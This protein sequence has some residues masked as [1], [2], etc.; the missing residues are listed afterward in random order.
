[1][2]R[3]E[4]RVSANIWEDRD[5]CAL[6]FGAQWI[7]EF[8]LSQRDLAH[9]GVIALRERRWSQHARGM[10][11]EVMTASLAEL[12]H[13]RYVVVDRDS[14]ELLVRT[15]I[16]NDKI[17]RQPNV[18]RA[19][20]DHL[21]LVLSAII[22]AA[23]AEE[24]AKVAQLDMGQ[25]SRAILDE[26]R[27][28]LETPGRN[29]QGDPAANP[30]GNPSQDPSAG[31]PG[32][33]GVVTAVTT[34]FPVPRT[35]NPVTPAGSTRAR[36]ARPP[37]TDAAFDQFWATYPL[38]VGKRT[39]RKA[40]DKAISHTDPELIL[41]GAQRYRDLPGREPKYTAHPATWLNADRWTDEPA[42]GQAGAS[43]N[44]QPKPSTTDA[45]VAAALAAGAEVQA[46]IDR[47]EI[48]P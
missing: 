17:Y 3:S 23:L 30:S 5:Y 9:D 10:T 27:K 48:N 22:R 11:A 41:A 28:A 36:G 46:M 25:A 8:L 43:P 2:A 26:M 16:R 4:G 6:S 31:T 35:S 32:V 1:M 21:P 14:E 15:L 38:R 44:G 24:L 18:L 29:P 34:G 19:A 12:E 7:Y 13:A 40:W 37:E 45:R 33:R 39:A 20:A 47:K 42:T